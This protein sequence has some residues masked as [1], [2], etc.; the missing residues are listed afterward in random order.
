[1]R[2]FIS[3]LRSANSIACAD[4]ALGTASGLYL[5]DLFDRLGLTAEL[6]PKTRLI[7]AVGGEPV[8]VCKAVADGN[9]EL[10]IQQIAEIGSVPGVDLVGPLPPEIQHVTVFAVAVAAS[11]QN[12]GLARNFVSYL[13]SNAAKS[14]IA[15]NGMEAR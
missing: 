12:L 6:E 1:V 7:G 2:A 4:P 14:V 15:S 3:A 13:T 8:V 9:A 11:T 10:G 5:V